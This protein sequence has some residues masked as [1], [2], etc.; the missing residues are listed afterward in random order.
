MKPF[1]L[2]VRIPRRD[3]LNIEVPLPPVLEVPL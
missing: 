2:G 1:M 3:A